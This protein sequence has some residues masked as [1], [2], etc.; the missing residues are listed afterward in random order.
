M[1][2]YA[3]VDFDLPLPEGHRF[4]G[5]KYAMLKR[6]LLEHHILSPDQIHVSPRA[7]QRDLLRVH[8]EEY[9]TALNDGSID[10]R[11]MRRIGFPWSPQIPRRGERT[12]GGA[13]A[14][15]RAALK[16]GLSGQ[17]AGGTHHAHRDFG[18]GFC[19][20]NDLAAVALALLE[21][22]LVERVAIIDLDVHQGD[23]NAAILAKH[24]D[25]FILDVHGAKNF[26]FRKVESTLDVPLD[27]EVDDEAYLSAITAHLPQVWGFA[28]DIVLYQAG[29]DPLFSDKLGRLQIS[30]EG[31]M[32]R[33]TLV[34]EG[35]RQRGIPCSMAIG[36]GY[37]DPIEDTVLAYANT[38]RVAKSVYGF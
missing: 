19:I 16:N 36:G 33:D 15:A 30:F 8:S 10:P 14:A 28:P 22:G 29:V 20:Y 18:A 1:H 9:V 3:S 24:K 4:P 27:D 7:G 38:Y 17:M 11:I 35:C 5:Q 23:G 37:A 13:L 34:L 31:L 2:F 12:V 21:E 6:Y 26:P 25:I 32:K